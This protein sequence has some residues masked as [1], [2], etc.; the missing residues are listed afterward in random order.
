M[1]KLTTLLTVMLI[2]SAAAIAQDDMS[3]EARQYRDEVKKFLQE[4]GFA[5]TVD[6][7]QVDF[8]K[9]GNSFWAI[10]EG[11]TPVMVTFRTSGYNNEYDNDIAMLKALADANL[12][13]TSAKAFLFDDRSVGFAVQFYSSDAEQFKHSFYKNMSDLEKTKE[14]VKTKYN[15]IY[16]SME[17]D[18]EIAPFSISSVFVGNVT[19]SGDIISDY[20]KSIYANSS[21]YLKPKLFIDTFTEGDYDLYVKVFAPDGLS[22]G[23]TSPAGYSF[24][25]T[26]SLKKDTSYYFTSGWGSSESGNWQAGEYRF[27]FYYKDK[28]IFTKKFNVL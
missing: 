17:D 6:G 18:K 19:K 14:N 28:L 7:N 24:K 15:E 16:D 11:S 22:A 21:Q 13:K 4:E 27:E 20:G 12:K 2:I 5:P 1:K 3:Y 25:S 10:F 26:L 9:E 23:S 8:K